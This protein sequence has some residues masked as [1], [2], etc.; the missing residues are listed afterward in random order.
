V[1]VPETI[2]THQKALSINLDPQIFGS[3]AEI[4]AGQEV[5]RWF[6]QVG[7]ASGTVAKTI[8]AYDKEVSD[9]LYGPGTRYV[10]KPR[11]QSMLEREWS[12]LLSQLSISR[13]ATT[14]FFSFVDT[15]SARN[16]SG[17]NEC[18]GWIG[19]RFQTQPQCPP[20]DLILHINLRD[21]SNVA[22]QDAVGIL[23]VNLIYAAF[24]YLSSADEFLTQL[25]A[26]LSLHRI[27]FDCVEH[28]GPA[29]EQWSP[30]AVHASLVAKH[31]A[32][33]VFFPVEDKFIPPTELLY[34]RAIVLAP[35]TFGAVGPLQRQMVEATLA[36]LSK[37]D[38]EQ[39]KGSI[40]L[41]AL[42]C[43]ASVDG[44]PTLTA[45]QILERVEALGKLGSGVLVFR[46]REIYKMGA[47]VSR[48]T[49]A[50]VHF[51]A[52]LSVLVRVLQDSYK[53]L[54]SSLLEGI[55][56]LFRANVRVSV[57]PMPAV[58]MNNADADAGWKWKEANGLIGAQDI[59]PPEPLN[60]LYRY[61][62]GNGLILPREFPG[63]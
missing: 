25:A 23:G 32:E 3:F 5:A 8:S 21:R 38:L 63:K 22:Q 24:H 50:R 39:S 51:A 9:D 28:K 14:R 37:Q 42:S 17:D 4:G 55:A 16:F 44:Q 34:K 35:G 40:G 59:E 20:S 41:F 36:S 33:A 12:D 10:S 58:A 62:I 7:A 60:H 56:R 2:D 47:F 29:F 53:D 1:S 61:L 49:K 19:L 48:F 54:D 15:V 13:G 26:D 45:A 27:E 31:L 6:L 30:R 11:L 43:A 46:Q 18:H 57:F 52:E